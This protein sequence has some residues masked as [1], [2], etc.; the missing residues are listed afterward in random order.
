MI[1]KKESYLC[2]ICVSSKKGKLL[3]KV[4]NY[5]MYFW[6]GPLCNT[7]WLAVRPNHKNYP[8]HFTLNT[9]I[10]LAYKFQLNYFNKNDK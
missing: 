6:F 3:S 4:H 9:N 10:N 8:H 2:I 7:T 5:V 1:L